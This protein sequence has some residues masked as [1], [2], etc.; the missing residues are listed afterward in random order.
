MFSYSRL[1]YPYLNFNPFYFLASLANIHKNKYL[2]SLS[3]VVYNL[4]SYSCLLKSR[5]KKNNKLTLFTEEH[6][7]SNEHHDDPGIT[8]RS[9][10]SLSD[11]N[12]DN[13]DSS[14]LPKTSPEVDCNQNGMPSSTVHFE[15]E[16]SENFNLETSVSVG[17]RKTRNSNR[18]ET[19]I[20]E[21]KCDKTCDVYEF[22]DDE[23]TDELMLRT[24]KT[25]EDSEVK[26]I[27]VSHLGKEIERE[28]SESETAREEKWTA[29]EIEQPPECVPNVEKT[30]EKSGRLKLTLR[31]KR[32]PVLDEVIESGTSLSDEC[33]Q[34]EYEILRVEG[35]DSTAY[36]PFSH[37]KKRHKSK[38][39]KRE[40]RSKHTEELP[41]IPMKRL[42]LIFGNESHTI[43]IP[44]TSSNCKT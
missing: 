38:D 31:M 40:R 3:F 42:R 13:Q 23:I 30:P 2:Y 29:E 19:P 28:K 9:N 4:L 26:D 1:K 21:I 18:T 43:D 16:T 14:N 6:E 8:L 35:V 41:H 44:S 17:R 25:V 11:I 7:C 5:P 37:R 32:S 12:T 39:R 22:N 36:T 33:L 15:E 27:S 34:P 20:Q 10:K 24:T